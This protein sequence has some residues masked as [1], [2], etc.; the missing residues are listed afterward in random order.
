MVLLHILVGGGRR[1]LSSTVEVLSY[2]VLCKVTLIVESPAVM[3]K[4]LVLKTNLCNSNDIRPKIVTNS[5]IN[6]LGNESS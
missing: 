3:E 2:S 1:G 5:K 6:N 4:L